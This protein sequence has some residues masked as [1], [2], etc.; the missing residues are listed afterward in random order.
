MLERGFHTETRAAARLR[1]E[2]EFLDALIPAFAVEVSHNFALASQ[3][4]DGDID[5]ALFELEDANLSALQMDLMNASLPAGQ[6]ALDRSSCREWGGC[7][8]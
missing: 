7:W 3:E 8:R 6:F 5:P 2:R 1:H 4:F